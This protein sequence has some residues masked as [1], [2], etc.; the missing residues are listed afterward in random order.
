[1]KK[2]ETKQEKKKKYWGNVKKSI[3]SLLMGTVALST[4]PNLEYLMSLNNVSNDTKV[5]NMIKNNNNKVET[6]KKLYKEYINKNIWL[7][8]EE[9][10]KFISSFT[11]YVI[12]PYGDFFTDDVIYNM[13]A[14]ASTE[15]V[16]LMS[17]FEKEHAWWAGDYQP[18]FN[19]LDVEDIDNEIILAHEQLHA[20]T[21]LGLFDCGV[22][23]NNG[24]G[25]NEGFTSSLVNDDKAYQNQKATINVL[26]S[27]LGYKEIYTY[28]FNRDLDGFKKYLS[29]YTSIENVDKI[30]T[31]L[32]N[33][34]YDG[35]YY[36]FLKNN[37][38]LSDKQL[39]DYLNE[40]K[41]KRTREL[42][43][44]IEIFKEIYEKK[45][46][47][48]VEN[49]N[50]GNLLFGDGNYYCG[51]NKDYDITKKTSYGVTCYDAN[52]V[53]ITFEYFSLDNDYSK[54]FII[55]NNNLKSF[56]FNYEIKK[57]EKESKQK[58]K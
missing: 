52:H 20:I 47:C 6:I 28:Y 29:K 35:Y 33:E 2:I 18:Y 17:D 4:L 30:I 36:T 50:L 26:G 23:D 21:K 5:R 10:Q 3:A 41:K 45:Y 39:N 9:K 46:N 15:R 49:S 1:M 44:Y 37:N 31:N 13:C 40:I 51:I 38:I 57:F 34:T 27:I 12:E 25:L 11:K 7:S 8:S 48:S 14:V 56:N 54:S 53:L 16:R 24:Y 58:V 19:L 32:K 43:D 42:Y 55:N 22:A